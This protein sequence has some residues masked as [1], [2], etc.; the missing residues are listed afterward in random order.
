MMNDDELIKIL[1]RIQEDLKD[2][3]EWIRDHPSC[4][5]CGAIVMKEHLSKIL[6]FDR[7]P[8]C[9]HCQD[10]LESF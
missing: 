6:P 7:F 4:G 5:D 2:I 1:H 8:V 9:K 10:K 3:N